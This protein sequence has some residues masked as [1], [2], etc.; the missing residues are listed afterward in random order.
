MVSHKTGWYTSQESRERFRMMQW[1]TTNYF[2]KKDTHTRPKHQYL[3]CLWALKTS[4]QAVLV[5][6][7]LVLSTM[8]HRTLGTVRPTHVAIYAMRLLIKHHRLWQGPSVGFLV[9]Q[10]PEKFDAYLKQKHLRCGL[11]KNEIIPLIWT[12]FSKDQWNW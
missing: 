2:K 3:P 7:S 4:G 8:C 10:C 11:I 12:L 1:T 6:R 5:S 9:C